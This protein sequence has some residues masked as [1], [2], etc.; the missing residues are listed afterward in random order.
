MLAMKQSVM[1]RSSVLPLYAP[2]LKKSP[3]IVKSTR[4]SSIE[5]KTVLR[6]EQRTGERVKDRGC[7]TG[8]KVCH[9]L[10]Q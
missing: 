9:G 8:T 7:N 1:G 10:Q 6:Q 2:Q 4:V 3:N 5:E